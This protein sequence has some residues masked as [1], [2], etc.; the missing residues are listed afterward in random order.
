MTATFLG[1]NIFVDAL[2]GDKLIGIARPPEMSMGEN[3]FQSESRGNLD[4]VLSR[5]NF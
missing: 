2:L 4:S 3:G 5:A 1:A